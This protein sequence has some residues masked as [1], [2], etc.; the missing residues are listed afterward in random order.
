M[1]F[2]ALLTSVSL[3][4]CSKED[5]AE[6]V[7]VSTYQTGSI[8]G[9]AK[10]VFN[11][12]ATTTQY[13]PNGTKVFLTIEYTESE[14]E[15]VVVKGMYADKTTINDGKFS[16]SNIPT[17][18]GGVSVKITGDGFTANYTTASRSETH[19]YSATAN[20]TVLPNG[21]AFVTLNYGEGTLFQ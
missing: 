3:T 15:S 18:N 19:A 11:H 6:P 8:S 17:L 7:D 4:S 14:D 12:D 1:A 20:A 2:L 9:I 16:F 5:P 21:T 10:A 13:A